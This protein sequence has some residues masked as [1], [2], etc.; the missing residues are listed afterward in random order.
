MMKMN[1]MWGFYG[2]GNSPVFLPE[3][4]SPYFLLK[5]KQYITPTPPIF[6]KESD[7]EKKFADNDDI[8]NLYG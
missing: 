6:H 7:P 4:G 5:K 8:S 3:A 2:T 1:R